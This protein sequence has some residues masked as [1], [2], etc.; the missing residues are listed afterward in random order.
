M[1]ETKRMVR[2]SIEW[3]S[4]N[5]DPV[6]RWIRLKAEVIEGSIKNKGGRRCLGK[7]PANFFVCLLCSER[8]VCI[9]EESQK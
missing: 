1:R 2:R 9:E 8:R 5:A 3:H 4:E 6:S 7:A